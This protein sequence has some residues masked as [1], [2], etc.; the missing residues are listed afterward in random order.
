MRGGL[1]N[2]WSRTPTGGH[3]GR[4]WVALVALA[5]RIFATHA[6][7]I[8]A[9]AGGGQAWRRLAPHFPRPASGSKGSTPSSPRSR[10]S[11]TPSMQ[12]V[13]AVAAA[14]LQVLRRGES[15]QSKGSLIASSVASCPTMPAQAQLHVPTSIC[16]RARDS[17]HNIMQPRVSL[18]K[19]VHQI[20]QVAAHPHGR[21][22]RRHAARCGR[23]F[24]PRSA[25]RR[26]FSA[27][28]ASHVGGRRAV[29]SSG[30][31]G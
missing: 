22:R 25:R 5:H 11:S 6:T 20:L 26:R 13:Q 1:A 3:I 15:L 16:E 24:E 21:R 9:L 14:G 31:G 17:I 23:R 4:T 28:P 2:R 10:R 18:R 12:I 27:W 19:A 8:I 29:C 30:G 7:H